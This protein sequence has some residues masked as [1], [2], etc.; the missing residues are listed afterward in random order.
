MNADSTDAKY[1]KRC[2]K[3]NIKT[4]RDVEKEEYYNI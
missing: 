1:N 2:A 4:K 3:K